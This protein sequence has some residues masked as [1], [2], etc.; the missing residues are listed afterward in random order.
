LFVDLVRFDQPWLQALTVLTALI[1]FAGVANWIARRLVS[2]LVRRLL[3]VTPLVAEGPLVAIVVQRLARIVPAL[4]IQLGISAVPHLPTALVTVT[5]NVAAAFIILTIALAITGALGIVNL[6]YQ[7]RPDAQ[8][9][10]IKGYVEVVSI[11]VYAASAVLI[12][13]ALMDRS[14]LLLLSGLG[15]LAAVLM[16]VFKDTILSLVASVQIG[17]N[18]MLRVGDWIEMPQQNADGDVI[19]IALHTVK[20]QNWDKTI[21]TVP[22]YRLISESFK[23]WRGMAET[24]ARRIKRALM[25]DQNSARFLTGDEIEGLKRFVLLDSYIAEK[26]RE[27]T[28]WNAARPERT[29][30]GVNARRITNIGTFRA[31]VSA[32]LRDHPGIS[33]RMTMLVR[34]LAPTPTGLPLEI[35]AFTA[36]TKWAEYE[37]IQGDIFDHLLAILPEFHLRLFQ[38]P[39]GLDVTALLRAA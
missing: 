23:N 13:A 32:Y 26:E 21:T 34:Q 39:S 24:G 28:R 16:L 6:L 37:Q 14:P 18:D 27:L 17:S 3:A 33:D 11:L 8:N 31:Y 2:R 15:A 7:R 29:R 36:T 1:L 22:T 25:I 20:I 12:L 35:Y 30:D 38:Q 9:R 10:P 19:D 5:R 4:I